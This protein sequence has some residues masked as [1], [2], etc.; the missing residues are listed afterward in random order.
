VTLIEELKQH[1]GYR[2][3]AYRDTLGV[4][5]IGYG[6]NI[7]DGLSEPLAARILE[8]IVEERRKDLEKALPFWKDLSPA[9]Q[10]V[11]LNMAYNLGMT[12]FLKFKGTLA[13]AER[14]DIEG[15]CEGLWHSLW[16]EQ[17]GV[18]ADQL[19]EKYRAG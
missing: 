19:I 13:A 5:T 10:E 3:H 9:R 11:F 6:L 15:V 7:D 16:Y 2:R 18:R 14:G 4:L 8:W 12:R 17:V 1:E